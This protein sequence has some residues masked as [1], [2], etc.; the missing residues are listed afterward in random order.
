[1]KVF[2]KTVLFFKGWLPLPVVQFGKVYDVDRALARV[3]IHKDMHKDKERDKDK[4]LKR[5][6][7][8]SYIFGKQGVQVFQISDQSTGQLFVS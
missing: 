6:N 8:M 4:M 2:H 7:M 5:P 3:D 1:M